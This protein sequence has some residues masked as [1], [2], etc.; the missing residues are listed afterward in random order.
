MEVV[1]IIK[2]SNSGKVKRQKSGH[3][4]EHKYSNLLNIMIY[5]YLIKNTIN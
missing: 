1:D 4:K 3:G 5:I 2:N